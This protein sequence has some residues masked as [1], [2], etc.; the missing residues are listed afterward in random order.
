[1]SKYGSGGSPGGDAGLSKGRCWPAN[2]GIVNMEI[3]FP[4]QYVDQADLERYDGV[5][6]GKYTVGLGQTK[7]GFCGDREDVNSLCLTVLDRLMRNTPGLTYADVGRLEVGTETLVDK[8][9]SVKSVLMQLFEESGNGDVEGVD[10]TNACYGGTAA[11]FN[12]VSW[13]ESSYWDGRFAVAVAA[14]IAVY[15]K[16]NARP[17]GG[18]GAVAMLIGP[19]APLV[20]DRGLRAT[21]VQHVYDFY[22]PDLSSEYPVVDGK[23]S[24][25]CYLSALDRC[26]RLYKTKWTLK[27]EAKDVV[28]ENDAVKNGVADLTLDAFDAV[29][30]HTPYCKLVQK[31]F[32]RL[33]LNDFLDSRNG[34]GGDSSSSSAK[35]VEDEARFSSV[36]LE[37]TYFDRDVEKAFMDASKAGFGSKTKPS[38]LLSTNVGNMYTCSLYGCLASYLHTLLKADK[39]DLKDQTEGQGQ[40]VALFSYGSG[41]VASLFS[42]RVVGDLSLVLSSV[43]DL[44]A[45]LEARE[46]VDPEAFSATMQA[47]E[48]THHLAP[49]LPSAPVDKLFPGTWY[50][51]E[52]DSMHRRKYARTPAS[53]AAAAHADVI[54]LK[55]S[56]AAPRET[57]L[58]KTMAN[59]CL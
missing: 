59:G 47:R 4:S 8:S 51:T 35:V 28:A 36:K 7:M 6:A 34:S 19:D 32:A 44:E 49:F 30:F 27:N 53:P 18:A 3:Y 41:S 5:S 26:Y 24:V 16:G 10:S 55:T 1:M 23:L 39:G 43:A 21:N 31:S 56:A 38:L 54:S 45:R 2:V 13:V 58:T 33:A 17:T 9:K 14:D 37:D 48:D 29:L 25:Q 52:V 22:K 42:L 12:C 40:R 50:L 57:T 15:A 11:L 20:L 46:R